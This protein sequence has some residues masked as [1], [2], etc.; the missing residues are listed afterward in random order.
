M[1]R[2]GNN[3]SCFGEVKDLGPDSLLIPL[4]FLFF[5][6]KIIIRLNKSLDIVKMGCNQMLGHLK[7][8]LQFQNARPHATIKLGAL[9]FHTMLRETFA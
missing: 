6:Q 9:G 3:Q 5:L 7:R 8:R 2:V 1:I 4:Y